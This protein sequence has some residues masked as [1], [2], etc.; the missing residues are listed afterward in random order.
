MQTVWKPSGPR[1]LV[2]RGYDPGPQ[3][4]PTQSLLTNLPGI[5][6]GLAHGI[7]DV[8]G[9]DGDTVGHTHRILT[10]IAL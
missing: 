4:C 6:R 3:F 9:G 8:A 1:S 10:R 5:E 7:I 2:W